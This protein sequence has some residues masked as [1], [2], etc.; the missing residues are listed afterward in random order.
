LEI[1]NILYRLNVSIKAFEESLGGHHVSE[2]G[3]GPSEDKE[4]G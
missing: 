3:G 1:G 4:V 2:I